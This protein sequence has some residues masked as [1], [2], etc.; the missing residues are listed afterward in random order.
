[1]ARTANTPTA[2]LIGKLRARELEIKRERAALD[3]EA[4]TIDRTLRAVGYK[5]VGRKP[6]T[7]VVKGRVV[8]R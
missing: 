3:R 6:G 4:A 8:V 1:M 7:R 5:R 2:D